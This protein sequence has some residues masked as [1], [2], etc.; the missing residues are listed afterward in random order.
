[1]SESEV[2]E[3]NPKRKEIM[4]RD[5]YPWPRIHRLPDMTHYYTARCGVAALKK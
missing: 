5:R 2:G 3:K 4:H 1:M